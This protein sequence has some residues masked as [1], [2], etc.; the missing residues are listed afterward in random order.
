MTT[1]LPSALLT[2]RESVDPVLRRAVA[3]LDP[4]TRRVCEYHF[5][6]RG[7]DG[8]PE[9]GGGKAL[10]PAMVLLSAQSARPPGP[11]DQAVAAAAAV[12]LVHN[13]SLLHDDVMDGDTSRRHRATAWTVF[14]RPAA[15]LAGDALLSLATEVLLNS[16]SPHAAAAARSLSAT[17]RVLIAGQA[18]DLDFEHRHDVTLDECLRMA[19]DKTAALLAC[20]A[21]I[22]ALSAGA[23][24]DAVFGLHTFGTEL[25]MAFQLVDDLLGLWGDPEV[26]GK[27]VLSDL[28]ARKKTVPVVHALN[29][30]TTA[31]ERLRELYARPEPLT[32]QQLREAAEMVQ[33]AGSADWTRRECQRRLTAADAHLPRGPQDVTEAL[34]ELATFIVRRKL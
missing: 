31:G 18:A 32:E 9:G 7:A 3:Q 4:D 25:G 21:S 26:T 24:Q 20:A 1:V 15:L 17:T 28:R 33:R 11:P 19:H 14:G 12:E 22:G 16:T 2:A 23:P 10:R 5:G 27:P 29:S 30:G 13:F 6:W 8:S 34:T